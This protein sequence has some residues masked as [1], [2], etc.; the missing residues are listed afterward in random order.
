[1][2]N[3]NTQKLGK[4]KMAP[5][6]QSAA[7][8]PPKPDWLFPGA[9]KQI[10]NHHGPSNKSNNQEKKIAEDLLKRRAAGEPPKSSPPSQLVEYVEFLRLCY[11]L[12]ILILF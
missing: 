3:P 4:R 1:M 6:A 11:S 12:A 2:S 8:R 7:V 9:K 5:V 10:Q